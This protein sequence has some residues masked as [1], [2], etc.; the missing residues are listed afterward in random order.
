MDI[1]NNI[2][3]STCISCFTS[4]YSRMNELLEI[5]IT[6]NEKINTDLLFQKLGV[7]NYD[8]DTHCQSDK[9]CKTLQYILKIVYNKIIQNTI[10]IFDFCEYIDYK[11]IQLDPVKFLDSLFKIYRLVDTKL[12]CILFENTNICNN[13]DTNIYCRQIID[14]LKD[15]PEITSCN[16][17]ELEKGECYIISDIIFN[18]NSNIVFLKLDNIDKY[19]TDEINLI[20]EKII[21]SN[22]E[23]LVL[24]C[25]INTVP[26]PWDS[27]NLSFSMNIQLLTNITNIIACSRIKSISSS[28][29]FDV[30]D[31]HESFM[32]ELNNLLT[33]LNN[34]YII[35][36]FFFSAYMY[37]K[38]VFT[39]EINTI[40][41]RN[42]KLCSESR[43]IKT[44]MAISN[45]V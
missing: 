28:I 7:I 3:S 24:N 19:D 39:N 6:K 9:Y 37:E 42:K 15:I 4:C 35:T 40:I 25:K 17:R 38:R 32:H 11:K 2:C 30:S 23:C 44:K 22:M 45:D 16:I 41:E 27:P 5:L 33:A 26:F 14:L 18:Q 10:Y 43:F 1:T 8:S 13:I 21:D 12:I 20:F 34:N 29:I 36:N 31:N